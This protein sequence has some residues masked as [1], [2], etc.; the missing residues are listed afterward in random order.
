MTMETVST[1]AQEWQCYRDWC[2][3]SKIVGDPIFL[4]VQGADRPHC[5]DCGVRFKSPAIRAN[6]RDITVLHNDWQPTGLVDLSDIGYIVEE[7][8]EIKDPKPGGPTT[9]KQVTEIHG[10]RCQG[11]SVALRE[12]KVVP[13]IAASGTA[14]GEARFRVVELLLATTKRIHPNASEKKRRL[15]AEPLKFAI[16]EFEKAK[17]ARDEI[18]ELAQIPR[19]PPSDTRRTFL[20]RTNGALINAR[21]V[22][23]GLG[24]SFRHPSKA[25]LIDL[26]SALVIETIKGFDPTKVHTKDEDNP[27]K[28]ETAS[29]TAKLDEEVPDPAAQVVEVMVIPARE[30]RTRG[31]KTPKA[32]ERAMAFLEKNG[33]FPNLSWGR[34][35]DSSP[36]EN[37]ESD[38]DPDL[39]KQ[40]KDGTKNGSSIRVTSKRKGGNKKTA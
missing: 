26:K 35:V 7:E 5:R 30:R 22:L 25:K 1:A 14:L 19:T 18:R 20:R 36:P 40:L 34:P 33:G 27:P 2:G 17:V 38:L 16:E 21:R 13:A 24:E 15:I 10:R 29:E 11:V 8:V 23:N 37:Q 3:H 12:G 9:R 6:L 28:Q 4:E 39:V 31:T 32:R